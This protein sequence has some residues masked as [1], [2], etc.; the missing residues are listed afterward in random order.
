MKIL[1]LYPNFGGYGKMPIGMTLLMTI[2]KNEGH[3][4]ELFD[5]TF[6]IEDH[7]FNDEEMERVGAVEETDTTHLYNYHTY[8][9]RGK[10]YLDQ[11]TNP[12]H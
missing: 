9:Q 6:I 11:Q 5:V 7:N 10:Y 12:F 3:Q 1:F 8:E 2:L 4:V